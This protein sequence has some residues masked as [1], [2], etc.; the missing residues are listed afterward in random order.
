M[1]SKAN[2]KNE[3]KKQ[4]D[5]DS[6]NKS[7]PETTYN[8]AKEVMSQE[9]EGILNGQEE[10]KDY[11][12]GEERKSEVTIPAVL[13]CCDESTPFGKMRLDLL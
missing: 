13:P 4:V 1:P 7:A 10:S 11:T 3:E 12:D 9:V 8:T 2:E 5:L 6:I